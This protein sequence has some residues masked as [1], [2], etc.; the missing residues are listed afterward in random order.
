MEDEDL[1]AAPAVGIKRSGASNSCYINSSMQMLYCI[2][3]VRR[4]VV[5]V[6][7]VRWTEAVAGIFADLGA[8]TQVNALVV[9]DTTK[10]SKFVVSPHVAS[11]DDLLERTHDTHLGQMGDPAQTIVFAMDDLF[12]NEPTHHVGESLVRYNMRLAE[13]S[14][15]TFVS[16]LEK[17]TCHATLRKFARC[18]GGYTDSRVE[19]ASHKFYGDPHPWSVCD[20]N[21]FSAIPL[22]V[23]ECWPSMHGKVRARYPANTQS[24]KTI[25]ALLKK[26][27]ISESVE[28]DKCKGGYYNKIVYTVNSKCMYVMVSISRNRIQPDAHSKKEHLEPI[29]GPIQADNLVFAVNDGLL[30]YT[31][32]PIEQKT[33][34]FRAIGAILFHLGHYVFV[35][36][37]ED[38]DVTHFYDDDKVTSGR[39]QC[40]SLMATLGVTVAENAV[41]LL[42]R[43]IDASPGQSRK[44][45]RDA[46]AETSRAA[47]VYDDESIDAI[48]TIYDKDEQNR[49]Q[50]LA[51]AILLNEAFIAKEQQLAAERVDREQVKRDKAMA[52][53]LDERYR[54]EENAR[55]AKARPKKA[56]TKSAPEVIDLIDEHSVPS[57]KNQ[58]PNDYHFDGEVTYS[59]VNGV[60]YQ[61]AQKR[62]RKNKPPNTTFGSIVRAARMYRA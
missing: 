32:N 51:S 5:S 29:M 4:A 50:R 37:D 54:A 25:S 7:G 28:N 16:E 31:D 27:E 58:D 10:K 18:T 20:V 42:Y 41:Q 59:Y 57:R 21:Y 33:R 26:Q 14:G 47:D 48:Q 17:V 13:L 22:K 1:V 30:Y 56:P 36:I 55:I 2:P 53:E 40:L 38:A 43:C 39:Q 62:W 61:D 24:I 60:R 35:R 52:S 45:A 23:N 19:S 6:K 46:V 34:S 49:P 12:A 3:A 9:N 11:L 8:G 44:R 15:R